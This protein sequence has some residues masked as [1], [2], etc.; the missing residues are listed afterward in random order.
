MADYQYINP[1]GTIIPDTSTILSDVQAEYKNV[2]GQDLIVTSDT[3]Q[4]VLITAEALSR[5]QE[6]NNNAALANEINPNIAGGV[7][8]DAIMALTGIGRTAATKT[9]VP[10][11]AL[12]GVPGTIIPGGSQAKTSAGDVFESVNNVTLSLAG[13]GTIDFT[14]IEYGPIP[15]ASSALDTIVS[16]VLGWE[17]VNNTNAGILGTS[18]QSDQAARA[19][20]NNTL[21]FQGVALPVAITSA[22]YAT[23]GVKSLSFLENYNNTPMGMLIYVTSG[24][25][26]DDTTW[27]LVTEGD[28][29]VG[30]T[31]MQFAES[32]QNV[33]S[34]NPWPVADYTT[35]GDITLSGLSTQGGG[36]WAGSL[37]IGDI[38]LVK[39]QATPSQNGV[40]VAASG[41]WARD[42]YNA[43]ATTILGSNSGISLV[44]NSIYACVDGGT[45]LAVASALLENKSS[46]CN[47]NGNETVNIVEPASGQTYP[48]KFDRPDVVEVLIKI[49]TTNGSSDNIKQT[50]LDY[51]NG[52]LNGLSGFVVG[53]DVSPFEISGAIA[54]VYPSYFISKVEVSN[55]SPT[56]YSTD[57][58]PIGVNQIAYTQQSYI[59]VVIA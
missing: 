13:T 20:R 52:L 17:T 19:Y 4:G 39:N 7:F 41:A 8:L 45:D 3:P 11:V 56:S 53:A 51:A 16:N 22:L 27:D 34:P 48:V 1:T 10:S 58:L 9:L 35:T 24:S 47:W 38:I 57:V 30:T 32:L 5:T 36:D 33:P 59:L 29:I 18:T 31:A 25:T 6:V 44:A 42:A 23:E 26:L 2:F 12:T 21:A 37:T 28:I 49:T 55:I 54:S 15:C 40:Y 14:S 43:A 50:V 46:G